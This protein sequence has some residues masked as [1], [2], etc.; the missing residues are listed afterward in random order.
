[1]LDYT[2]AAGRKITKDFNKLRNFLE[3]FIQCAYIIYLIVALCVSSG[4]LIANIGF[5]VCSISYFAFYVYAKTTHLDKKQTKKIAKIYAYAKKIVKLLN[6]I[7]IIYSISVTVMEITLLQVLFSVLLVVGFILDIFFMILGYIFE[8]WIAYLFA[9]IEKDFSP[10]FGL[11]KFFNKN[12]GAPE[13]DLEPSKASLYLEQMVE[14]EE[15][16][17]KEKRKKEKELKKQEKQDKKAAK[18]NHTPS[19]STEI[20]VSEEDK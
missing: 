17:A 13:K 20:A 2:R 1:M 8:E 18:R 15:D 7:I 12:K 9:G 19:V 11:V 16:A 14:H 3:P 4:N 5:L 10:I 6:L